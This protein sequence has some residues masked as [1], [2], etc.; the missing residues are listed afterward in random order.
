V[1]QWIFGD[2]VPTWTVRGS[3]HCRFRFNASGCSYVANDLVCRISRG[4]GDVTIVALSLAVEK[5]GGRL[6][7]REAALKVQIL[8]APHFSLLIFEDVRE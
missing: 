1:N 8:F 3:L 2:F 4:H 6:G 7:R 5:F